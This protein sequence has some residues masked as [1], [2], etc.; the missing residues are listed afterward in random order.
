MY[1]RFLNEFAENHATGTV[2]KRHTYIRACI[3]DAIEDGVISKDPTYRAIVKGKKDDKV[4][5]LKYLNFEEVK[6][7]T[8]EIKKDMNQHIFLDILFFSPLRLALVFSL[9]LLD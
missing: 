8:H 9:K 4:E 2:K 3:R 7:L 6:L 1:Q 5:E